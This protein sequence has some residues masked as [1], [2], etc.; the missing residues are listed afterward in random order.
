ML[1]YSLG[2][3]SEDLVAGT[4]LR[5][6]EG[7]TIASKHNV[8]NIDQQI[9]QEL[10]MSQDEKRGIY[11][12]SQKSQMRMG[13]KSLKPSPWCLFETIEG[14]LQL[15]YMIKEDWIHISLWLNHKD[16]FPQNTMRKGI[17]NI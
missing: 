10:P 1:R 2:L 13:R 4:N 12:R 15:T 3:A 9:Y 17:S 7:R 14:F 11:H 6:G 16:F 8:I 5:L